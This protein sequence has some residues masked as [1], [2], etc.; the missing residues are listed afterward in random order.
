MNGVRS[1]ALNRGGWN[2]PKLWSRTLRAT[3]RVQH[4]NRACTVTVAPDQAHGFG[5][6]ALEQI[7]AEHVEA[8]EIHLR[9][10]SAGATHELLDWCREGSIR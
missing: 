8:I 6:Q 3:V 10:D 1:P 4:A 9:F 5:P 2:C 7:P